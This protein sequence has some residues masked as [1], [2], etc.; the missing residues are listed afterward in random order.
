MNAVQEA[1]RW[2]LPWLWQASCQAS[3]VILLVLALQWLLRKQLPARWSHALWLLV[4]FR[5][6]LPFSV[7]T[8]FSL[9]NWIAN[10]GGTRLS[11][12][13]AEAG[14]ATS[15][16]PDS[17]ASEASLAVA[18]PTLNPWMAW[19]A[20]IWLAGAVALP[21]YSVLA[22]WRLGRKVWAQRPVTD[23][24]VLNLLEDCKQEMRVRTPLS[25]IETS[26]VSGPALL[27]FI[28]PRLLLPAGLISA[29]SRPELRYV[30][31]HELGHV[32]RGDIILNWL[33]T[34]PLCLHWFNPL[35]WF[36]FHRMRADREVACDALAL[37]HAGDTENRSYGQTIIK[38]LENFS[39]PVMAPALAGI[40]E[41]KNQMQRR[42]SM[43][44]KFKK[45]SGWPVFAASACAVLALVTLTDA[46]SA[47]PA[48]GASRAADDKG[49]PQIASTTPAVGA[50]EVD[51]A[52][53]EII[54]TFDRDMGGGF[55]WTGGGPDYP[56]TPA[57][58]KAIW[59][60]KRTCVLPV[61]LEAGR[62]Y[63][64][65]I[66]STSYQ[67]FRSAAG[68]PARPSAV[69]FTTRGASEELKTKA[70]KPQIVGLT[71]KNGAQDVDPNLKEI[72]ITFNVPMGGG[73]SWTGGG[74]NYPTIPGG[75]K[76]YWTEDK[77]TCVLPVQLKPGWEY[78]LGLNSPSHK[79]FQSSGGV[80]LDPVVL[81]F[82]TR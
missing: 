3:V 67:N 65:G 71:P 43:I 11:A 26:A 56:P 9:F 37:S 24:A 34:V 8:R 25:L 68:T 77:K 28:R 39:R 18:V 35:V 48:G 27:G 52:L 15:P 10:P 44:A 23:Q 66:N 4:V 40:L 55:S 36:A 81:I 70:Q 20:G 19:L 47:Q 21:C 31:L 46:N 54:V 58:Q 1:T 22:T 7:E 50:T 73:F 63:R 30:F 72:R 33:I 53:T 57:G 13:F 78:R 5:L 59:R 75:K 51:P 61:K 79:N 74:E 82:K 41:T 32:K 80:P 14:A 42:I 38:L 29:F 45:T 16:G 62:Y 69:Y 64:V 49:P 76:P 2:F 17:T 60:D 6:V 12:E